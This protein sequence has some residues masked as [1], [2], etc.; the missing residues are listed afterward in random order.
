MMHLGILKGF[1][2]Q[3]KDYVAGCEELGIACTVVDVLAADWYAVVRNTPC[4]GYL[5]WPPC[6]SIEQK[7]LYDERVYFINH[8]LGKPVYPSYDECALHE[9]KRAVSYWLDW[10]G[11]PHVPSQVFAR[12]KDALAY[13]SRASYP[14]VFKS[15]IG[16]AASGVEIVGT[17]GR[18]RRL[19]R[20]IFG[21]KPF[22]ALGHVP[23]AWEYGL[24]WPLFGKAQKHY[25]IVQDFIEIKW[26]W[27]MVRIGES[28]F[29]HKKLLENGFASGSNLVGW[30]RP[31]VELLHL[32]RNVCERGGFR[33]M[34]VDVFETESGEFLV[35]ELQSLF[36][37]I[38]PS[39]MYIDGVPGRFVFQNGEFVFEEGLFNQFSSCLLRVKNFVQMLKRDVPE[40]GPNAPTGG[41]RLA[42]R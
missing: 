29:G 14:L 30:D 6:N 12:K 19:A 3:H 32:V 39:Q 10:T 28:Y 11:F 16:A 41:D 7:A 31:P 8:Y 35:N 25:L 34:C 24:P 9:N 33:S 38:S 20:R 42:G 4:D 15:S 26:E 23:V 22:F 36:C 18:A 5:V 2:R 17:A 13:L 21:I 1:D 27:R 40:L 37:S